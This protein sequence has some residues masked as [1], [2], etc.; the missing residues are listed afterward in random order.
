MTNQERIL[1]ESLRVLADPSS[2]P[3]TVRS[4]RARGNPLAEPIEQLRVLAGWAASNPA[5][6]D[7]A[8]RVQSLDAGLLRPTSLEVF[9]VNLGKLCNMSC[10]HCHVDA[11]PDRT[12]AIMDDA[13]V[14][15]AMEAMARSGAHT[16]DLTGG[17]PELHPAF[18]HLVAAAKSQGK[19][20]IDRCNLTILLVRRFEDL[21]AF[22]AAHEVEIV[23]S[24]PHVRAMNTDA[25]RGG[26]TWEKSIEAMRRLN[27]VGYGKGDPSHRLTLVSNPSGAFLGAGQETLEAEWKRELALRHGVQFDRLFVLNNMPISRFLEWLVESG[28][29]EAYME[30]VVQ[31]FNPAAV[32]GVMCRN[33]ISVGWNGLMYDCDFNQMLDM[34][35]DVTT[36]HVR[37]FDLAAWQARTIKTNRHC[38]GC[39]AGA[40]SSCGGQTT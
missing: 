31:A 14:G 28:N 40:G 2:G 19:H 12:D 15:A 21:P 36:P 35:A 13:T 17:A 23:A 32:P 20:V 9:Q 4:L 8:A 24:L 38:F 18:R 37:A 34:T 26:G 10:R 39:T 5:A 29:F 30:R 22:L 6:A 11:G 3:R 7:F 25:Q 27:A 33:T 16:L 1:E